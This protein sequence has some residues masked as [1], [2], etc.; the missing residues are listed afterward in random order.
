MKSTAEAMKIESRLSVERKAAE[1]LVKKPTKKEVKEPNKSKR[2]SS[3]FFDFLEEF[4]KEL[5][6]LHPKDNSVV[7]MGKDSW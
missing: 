2:A 7:T 1:E 6:E 4:R 5:T 3:A